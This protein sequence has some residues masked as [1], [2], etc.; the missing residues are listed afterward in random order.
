LN[1]HSSKKQT[2]ELARRLDEV[3]ARYVNNT[4]D[5]NDDPKNDGVH[6]WYNKLIIPLSDWLELSKF[7]DAFTKGKEHQD[8]EVALQYFPDNTL[9]WPLFPN[10]VPAKYVDATNE[11]W[12]QYELLM[13]HRKNPEYAH[14]TDAESYEKYA[15]ECRRKLKENPH[16]RD[17]EYRAEHPGEKDGPWNSFGFD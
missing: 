14:H 6:W 8:M 17:D 12:I 3:E 10:G 13:I 5:N 16:L 9:N 11:W 1:N 4:Y 7:G 2:D 15:R